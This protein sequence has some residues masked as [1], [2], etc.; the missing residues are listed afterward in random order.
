MDKHFNVIVVGD[1]HNELMKKYDNHEVDKFIV[2]EFSTEAIEKHRKIEI[3][4]YNEII[5]KLDSGDDSEKAEKIEFFID[6]IKEIEEMSD[7]EYYCTYTND[8]EIDEETGNAYSTQNPLGQFDEF[9]VACTYAY[10]FILK[11]GSESF[12]AKKG[13]IDWE[14]SKVDKHPYEVAWETVVERRKPKDEYEEGIYENMKNLSHY[15]ES[16]ESKNHYVLHN[17][18]IWAYAFLSE[19]SGWVDC[20]DTADQVK[21]VREYFDRFISGLSDKKTLT[22]Y[23]CFRKK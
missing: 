18:S 10:P 15:L 5:S 19:D 1:N 8:L 20:S 16:F 4:A 7:V 12:S 14:K 22:L 3:D 6:K 11:D 17:T 13:L 21:W 9:K 2:Y 23:E